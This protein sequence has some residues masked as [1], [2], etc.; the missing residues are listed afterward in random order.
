MLEG[1]RDDGVRLHRPLLPRRVRRRAARRGSSPPCGAWASPRSGRWPSARSWSAANT[2]SLARQAIQGG[3]AR[4]EHA[5]PGH[6]VATS[7]KYLPAPAGIAGARRLPDDRHGPGRSGRGSAPACA[8]CSSARASPRR[9][10][11]RTRSCRGPWTRC[12]PSRSSWR[13]S[14]RRDIDPR[15]RSPATLRRSR[16]P[17]WAGPSPSP[18]GC[19]A[20][21]E[22]TRTSCRTACW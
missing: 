16:R 6:R 8:W 7:Q 5:V 19:C 21:R 18:A 2:R 10:R 22:S 13:C 17:T 12:S 4:R 20:R 3:P 15:P 1:G 9:R 14:R 11:S